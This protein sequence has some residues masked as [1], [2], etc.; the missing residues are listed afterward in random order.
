MGRRKPIRATTAPPD[1][2]RLAV[3]QDGFIREIERV[4]AVPIIQHDGPT[5]VVCGQ[6]LIYGP[7][8]AGGVCARRDELHSVERGDA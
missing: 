1:V 7:S 5:C 4:Q 2:E 6:R 8:I 3:A